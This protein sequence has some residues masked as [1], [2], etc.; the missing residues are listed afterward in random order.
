MALC[1]YSITDT[2]NRLWELS[3][4]PDNKHISPKVNLTSPE[5]QAPNY[6]LIVDYVPS[7]KSLLI[8]N[9]GFAPKDLKEYGGCGLTGSIFCIFD[10]ECKPEEVLA[11]HVENPNFFSHLG[12]KPRKF[13]PQ[14]RYGSGSSFTISGEDFKRKVSPYKRNVNFLGREEELC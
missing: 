4:N 2:K 5:S 6:T 3:F 12:F 13:L 8:R 10:T 7:T 1:I 14:E 11:L 9:I